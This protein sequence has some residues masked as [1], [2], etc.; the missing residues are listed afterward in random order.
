MPQPPHQVPGTLY[1]VATPIGNLEDISAR[2]RRV[3]SQVDLIAAEDTRRSGALLAHLGISK[4]VESYH[5]HNEP[6]KAA[7][8]L[9]A[10]CRGSSVALIT[11]AGVP[12]ISDPGAHLIAQALEAGVA[13]SPI[14]GP[15]A[16]LAALSVSGFGA[17]RFLFAGYPPRKPGQR[18]QFYHQLAAM[19]VPVVIYEAPH[20]VRKSLDDAIAVLGEDRPAF[21]AREM[22][23]QFE[24][25]RR[26]PLGQLRAHYDAVDPLGEFT[27]VLGP[28]EPAATDPSAEGRDAA[29]AA[30]LLARTDLPVKQACAILSAATGLARNKAYELILQARDK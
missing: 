20:R 1:V 18:R 10:L 24:E 19:A 14:P 17:D 26:G 29:E 30:Q 12:V 9:G 8:L 21:I 2:A 28:A 7:S 4:P 5:E 22:T 3:L 16:V 25:F 13:V 15:S 6:Q 23:K 27:I 11:D